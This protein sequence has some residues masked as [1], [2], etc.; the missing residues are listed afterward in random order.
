MMCLNICKL[1]SF[2]PDGSCNFSGLCSWSLWFITCFISISGSFSFLFIFSDS[3]QKM[4][5]ESLSVHFQQRTHWD[6]F[7]LFCLSLSFLLGCVCHCVIM[8]SCSV[9][10]VLVLVTMVTGVCAASEENDL[11]YSYW[12]YRE[13]GKSWASFW[14]Q[15]FQRYKVWQSDWS[16]KL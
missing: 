12:N 16:C 13:G 3:K 9:L 1:L 14:S 4:C 11:D 2:K 5:Q 15:M 7:S 8:A 6:C 10:M